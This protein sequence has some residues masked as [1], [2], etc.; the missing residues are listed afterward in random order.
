MFPLDTWPSAANNANNIAKINSSGVKQLIN[1]ADT[2]SATGNGF[3]STVNAIAID[4]SGNMFVGG[5]FNTS[6]LGGT[7]VLN[8]ANRL[9]G[10]SST[11]V[12]QKVNPSDSTGA[13]TNVYNGQ[14]NALLL[15]AKSNLYIGGWYTATYNGGSSLTDNYFAKLNSSGLPR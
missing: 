1:A 7:G 11:G 9:Q 14:V 13:L 4:S 8:N 2:S 10:Y 5:A 3:N 12:L 15:D 6:Y